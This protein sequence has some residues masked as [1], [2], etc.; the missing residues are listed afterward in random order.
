MPGRRHF[1][2]LAA[3][4]GSSIAF[5]PVR[6]L[7]SRHQNSSGFFGV[8]AFIEN[9]PDAVFIM[10]TNVDVKTNGNAIKRT[11]LDFGSSVF[12]P[13]DKK[14]GGIPL[15]HNIAIKPNL[16]CRGKWQKVYTFER[17]RGV[18]TDA[19]FTEGIIDS[20]KEL[21]ISGNQFYIR[22]SNCPE[23][24][25]D[26]GYWGKNGLTERTGADLQDLSAKIGKIS[27]NDIQW[28]DV[29]QGGW[30]KKIPYLWPVNS[31]DSMLLNIAKFKAHPMG[32]T[33]CA[34]NLQGTNALNYNQHC[35]AYNNDMDIDPAHVVPSAFS[36][37]HANYLRHMADGIPR[38]DRLSAPGGEYP[39]IDCGIGQETWV[40]RCLDNNS[41]T[42]P[43][44]HIV[45]G[46]YGHDGNFTQGT[47]P[48]GSARDFMSNIII[49]GKNP[50]YVD[51]IG[52][53]LGGHEPGNFGL[54]HIAI[55]RG[56]A[57]VLNPMNIPVYEWKSDGTATLTPL[58]KFDRTPLVT[59][60]LPRDYNGQNE[61]YW[62]LCNEPYDY[63]SERKDEKPGTGKSGACILHQNIPNPANPNISIEYCLPRSGNVRLEIYNTNEQLAGILADGFHLKGS[64]LAVLNTR[65]YA[66]GTYYYRFRF[67]GLT[68]VKK[69]II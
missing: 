34:K 58:T 45:E 63:G 59:C 42:H 13:K 28:V 60:Y 18:V 41:V 31:P 40:T 23:D 24:F 50:F 15:T 1:L 11:A 52:H 7:G 27:E 8:H 66:S 54:F 49:F 56:F 55:E 51:I 29:P 16:T 17:S 68:E 36:K 44:L 64:H 39:N 20:M 57:S 22:E 37:I 47:G 9:H 35:R 61:P 65:E 38:W 62:H 67:G 33:L 19:N 26:D 21:G 14:S 46:I 12:V 5:S 2:K 53:W 25:E 6:A 3:A 4:A 30:F 43:G 10:R 32:L 48:E 69:M